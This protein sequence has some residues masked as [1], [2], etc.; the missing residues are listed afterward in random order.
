ME[1]YRIR[2]ISG[3]MVLELLITLLL[4]TLVLGSTYPN[5]HI[6]IEQVRLEAVARRIINAVSFARLSAVVRGEVVIL[7]GSSD[8]HH[9]D[10]A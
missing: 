7:C 9:C 3:L 10:G 1:G 4:V 2:K 8:Q 5:W 6:W